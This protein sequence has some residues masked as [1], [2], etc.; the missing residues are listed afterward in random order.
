MIDPS[1]TS[2]LATNNIAARAVRDID[3]ASMDPALALRGVLQPVADMIIRRGKLSRSELRPLFD[4]MRAKLRQEP[5]VV[6]IRVGVRSNSVTARLSA[7]E[8]HHLR[9]TQGIESTLIREGREE[10]VIAFAAIELTLTR[11]DLHAFGNH[12]GLLVHPHLLSR[13]MQRQRKSYKQLLSD[14]L[15]PMRAST[16]LSYV[17]RNGS[18][19]LPVEGGLLLG[20]VTTRKKR[21]EPYPVRWKLERDGTKV[22][23]KV[24]EDDNPIPGYRQRA[25]MMTFIDADSLDPAKTRLLL[26]LTAW[27]QT[28]E[29]A[30]NRWFEASAYTGTGISVGDS[31]QAISESM[32]D[33]MKAALK[34]VRGDDW[35]AVF[36]A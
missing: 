24:N 34:V 3:R 16:M 23:T 15:R 13:Y 30:I 29:V 10:P 22:D 20:T 28:Y 31:K 12:T 27:E 35:R 17:I 26:A 6:D 8:E 19:A 2:V 7:N 14:I 18:I 21:N 25:F 32:A 33:A 9:F 4:T 5:N 11:R 1:F 36:P